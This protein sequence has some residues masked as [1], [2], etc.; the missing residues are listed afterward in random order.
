MEMR[1]LLRDKETRECFTCCPVC[2]VR[3][4][5][6]DNLHSFSPSGIKNGATTDSVNGNTV[7]EIRFPCFLSSTCIA[8]KKAEIEGGDSRETNPPNLN[9]DR[10]NGISWEEWYKVLWK[11]KIAFEKKHYR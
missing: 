1:N 4:N 7:D 9:S 6:A 5:S 8:R 2:L 10:D 3:R 11:R